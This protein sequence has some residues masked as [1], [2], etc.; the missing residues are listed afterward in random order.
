MVSLCVFILGV[1]SL[2]HFSFLYFGDIFNKTIVTLEL[3][4]YDMII[5]IRALFTLWAFQHTL[6]E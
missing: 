2:F 6:V 1:L 3:V 5:V 4:G